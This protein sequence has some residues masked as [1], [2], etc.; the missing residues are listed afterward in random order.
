LRQ[1]RIAWDMTAAETT[2]ETLVAAMTGLLA[3]PAR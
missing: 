3:A 2:R 1:G